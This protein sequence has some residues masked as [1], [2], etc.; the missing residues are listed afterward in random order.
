MIFETSISDVVGVPGS[1]VGHLPSFAGRGHTLCGHTTVEDAL[2]R[3][4]ARNAELHRAG[5][6]GEGVPLFVS[7]EGRRPCRWCV[8][9][10][11]ETYLRRL[12]LIEAMGGR[13]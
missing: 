12:L 4:K 10:L 3:I 11:D 8:R 5:I 9:D 2:E 7:P 1:D 13:P 6:Y